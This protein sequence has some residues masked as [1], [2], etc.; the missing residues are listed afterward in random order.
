MGLGSNDETGDMISAHHQPAKKSWQVAA[1]SQI[2]ML[3]ALFEM[4]NRVNQGE[5]LR[6]RGNQA[7]ILTGV[8]ARMDTDLSARIVPVHQKRKV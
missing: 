8:V 3:T 4:D 5:L 6:S 1:V 7:A 2:A